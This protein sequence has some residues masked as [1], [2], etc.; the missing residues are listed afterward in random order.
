MLMAQ[1]AQKHMKNNKLQLKPGPIDYKL[2]EGSHKPE[3]MLLSMDVL[4]KL[5]KDIEKQEQ[6]KDIPIQ[7]SIQAQEKIPKSQQTKIN[8]SLSS[9][10]IMSNNTENPED[11]ITLQKY[12]NISQVKEAGIKS[13]KSKKEKL[14]AKLFKQNNKVVDSSNSQSYTKSQVSEPYYQ[15][16]IYWLHLTNPILKIERLAND[17]EKVLIYYDEKHL[18]LD[19][20]RDQLVEY[21]V[22]S[23][24][25]LGVCLHSA[26]L[27]ECD[28]DYQKAKT[29]CEMIVHLTL[30]FK[31]IQNLRNLYSFEDFKLIYKLIAL[32][33]LFQLS[34][35][36]DH[37][38]SVY[39][40]SYMKVIIDSKE[41]DRASQLRVKEL[42]NEINEKYFQGL[43]WKQ[44]IDKLL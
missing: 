32:C 38:I 22:P 28:L 4:S 40:K 20:L 18:H 36:I 30:I 15:K 35:N 26:T 34:E 10:G 39:L 14:P 19:F 27:E 29:T 13:K 23:K 8:A 9:S 12:V 24:S 31:K 1:V 42:E 5:V 33:C 41:T 3:S 21:L 17:L 6:Q 2:P 43:N 7:K 11:R 16:S 37:E 44:I 25:A